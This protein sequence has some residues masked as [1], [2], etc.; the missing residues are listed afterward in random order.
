LIDDFGAKLKDEENKKTGAEVVADIEAVTE[1][2]KLKEYES[3]TRQLVQ[4]ALKKRIKE[5]S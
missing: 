1:M 3:D 2:E 4:N 5:L